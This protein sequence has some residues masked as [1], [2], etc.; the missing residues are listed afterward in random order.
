MAVG[1]S[2]PRKDARVKVKGE[3]QYIFDLSVPDEQ[4]G[5]NSENHL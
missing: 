1:K 2:L 4:F 3:A 5:K